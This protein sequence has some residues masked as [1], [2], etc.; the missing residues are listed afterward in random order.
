MAGGAVRPCGLHARAPGGGRRG[1]ARLVAARPQHTRA[2]GSPGGRAATSGE[3]AR[4]G[5]RSSLQLCWCCCGAAVAFTRCRKPHP[6][7]SCIRAAC[8][9][10]PL[11]H[12]PSL[13]LT[14]TRTAPLAHTSARAGGCGRGRAAVPAR[15]LRHRAL[16]LALW[17]GRGD[18]PGRAAL[19][20]A[21]RRPMTGRASVGLACCCPGQAPAGCHLPALARCEPC[22]AVACEPPALC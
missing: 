15:V 19:P 8:L 9:A 22:S 6:P 12:L 7:A 20:R 21:P 4:A 2:V 18:Q 5:S 14:L 17:G 11:I 1:V 16:P 10:C 3:A 13:A